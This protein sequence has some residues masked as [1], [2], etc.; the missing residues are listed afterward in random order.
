MT[1]KV[2]FSFVALLSL[3]LYSCQK[4]E[5]SA[6][7]TGV[8]KDT[9][10]R[11]I[12]DLKFKL[13]PTAD[14]QFAFLVPYQ[15]N[16]SYKLY[17][18]KDNK[19]LADYKLI[20]D[21]NTG[22]LN[23]TVKYNF[24]IYENYDILVRS[25]RENND[26]V[27]IE[28][29]TIKNYI[30]H[31]IN[32]FNYEKLATI[33]QT[34]DF[35]ISPSRNI[36]Y[37]TDYI[38]NKLV[39]KRLSLTDKN[40]EVLDEDFFSLLIR[41]KNDNE[42][43]VRS[44]SYNNHFLGSDSCALLDYDVFTKKSSFIDWGSADYGRFSRVVNSSIM[45]SNPV[46]TGSISLINLTDETKR[47]YQADIG[48]LREYSFDNIY[49][50]N[51][52]FDFTVYDFSNTLPFLNS[53]SAVSYYDEDSGYYITV[54]YFQESSASAVY[55][56]MIIYKD[57]KVVYEQPYEKGRSFNFPR[58][59]N[60]EDNE[61]IFNQCY[62]YDSTIRFDGYYML[63]INTKEITLLQNDDNNYVKNDFFIFSNKNSFISVRPYEI[64]KITVN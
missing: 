31:Y 20:A 27:Y 7:D 17:L 36:I 29:F 18:K 45:V 9:I 21:N 60:L 39:L 38:N 58:L 41:S 46:Y 23:A 3:F 24:L 47:T 50:G 1:S 56:R 16:K 10:T 19:D 57:N 32:K 44:G 37:Y 49:L 33:N 51:D 62:E 54:E 5:T 64:Y 63:D 61:L 22:S 43:I 40:I 11:M 14:D 8:K 25:A 53:N 48:Y 35:D 34:I 13:N 42:L 12:N 59:I 6:V 4:G 52:I 2:A 28:E 30:H 15:Y 26:T 55:S